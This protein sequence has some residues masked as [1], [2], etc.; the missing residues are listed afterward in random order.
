MLATSSCGNSTFTARAHTKRCCAVTNNTAGLCCADFLRLI[1]KLLKKLLD[2]EDRKAKKATSKAGSSSGTGKTSTAQPKQQ[3]A[4]VPKPTAVLPAFA[5]PSG[6]EQQLSVVSA[7]EPIDPTLAAQASELTKL[8]PAALASWATTAKRSVGSDADELIKAASRAAA[9]AA[10]SSTLAA[11][12]PRVPA[13]AGTGSSR[14]LLV[15]AAETAALPVKS[16]VPGP[17]VSDDAASSDVQEAGRR[18]RR[19]LRLH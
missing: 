5:G 11:A 9:A 16:A 4:A 18:W 12:S 1:Y 7:G 19:I 6:S 8:D 17:V 15:S 13:A 14:V 3:V 2:H 10:P